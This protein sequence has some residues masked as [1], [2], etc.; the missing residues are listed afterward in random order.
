L[1]QALGEPRDTLVALSR[2]MVLLRSM[3][4]QVAVT[5]VDL[6]IEGETGSGKES[7]A[8]QLHRQSRRHAGPFCVVTATCGGIDLDFGK[9][10]ERAHGGTLFVDG[11]EAMAQAAQQHLAVLL[12]RRDRAREGHDSASDFR[13]IAGSTSPLHSAGLDNGLAYRLA[14]VRLNVPPLR[15]RREDIPTLFARFVREALDQ[16]GRERFDMTAADRK[17]LLEHDWPGNVRELR[18][19]AFAA[20]LDL[21]RPGALD[22]DNR[23][24]MGLS[25]RKAQF[26][27]LVILEALEA[28]G[29][30]VVRACALLETS[31]KSLYEKLQ[32]HGIDPAQFRNRSRRSGQTKGN[33]RAS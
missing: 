8:R 11:I 2:S 9:A 23:P 14:A 25:A 27:R 16:T 3:V 13:L 32:H 29:G 30:N 1:R 28:T 19:Y 24:R 20:V 26:E 5:D 18:S 12:D 10:A 4:A 33:A 22:T 17:R 6:A 15:E 21:P 31:R 7:W